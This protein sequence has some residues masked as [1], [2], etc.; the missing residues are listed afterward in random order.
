MKGGK[1]KKI[2]GRNLPLSVCEKFLCL[3]VKKKIISF[4]E[5]RD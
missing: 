5:K 3:H 4:I 2:L 1:E